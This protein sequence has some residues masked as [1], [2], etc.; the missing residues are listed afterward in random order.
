MD[1]PMAPS[2]IFECGAATTKGASSFQLLQMFAA[3]NKADNI[4]SRP[5]SR[6]TQARANMRNFLSC[7]G[8]TT[9][10][11]TGTEGHEKHRGSK[12]CLEP[13]GGASEISVLAPSAKHTLELLV[14]QCRA[15]LGEVRHI[16]SAEEHFVK[17]LK[18]E[19]KALKAQ[20][21]RL[22]AR[23]Q[24]SED[25]VAYLKTVAAKEEEKAAEMRQENKLLRA[26]ISNYMV[27]N[28][29]ARRAGH[30]TGAGR[31]SG[32]AVSS[33]PAEAASCAAGVLADREALVAM[34]T[35]ALDALSRILARAEA[36]RSQVATATGAQ[37]SAR[38]GGGEVREAARAELSV[39]ALEALLMEQ[40]VAVAT[41]VQELE[42]FKSKSSSALRQRLLRQEGKE[43][44]EGGVPG[45]ERGVVREPRVQA[46]VLCSDRRAAGDR[47]R[48]EEEVDDFGEEDEEVAEEEEGKVKVEVEET[49][50]VV[51]EEK[52]NH[53]I[54]L[55]EGARRLAAPLGDLAQ[56]VS[57]CMGAAAAI[58]QGLECELRTS[59]SRRLELV[60]ARLE[61]AHL[62]EQERAYVERIEQMER[63]GWEW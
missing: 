42:L 61:A 63:E 47:K 37:G 44:G 56:E 28:A 45:S 1:L 51:V 12:E 49:V 52:F 16:Q 9:S 54:P 30:V 41:H 55:A 19:Q 57:A 48:R 13:H 43:T 18:A 33:V 21:Q 23:L 59:E 11:E 20:M 60:Q 22:Q 4:R 29:Q 39:G 24:H 15:T 31:K 50:I 17:G 6:V 36:G 35:R 14:H 2:E 34:H 62:R 32:G 40:L 27:G 8:E 5:T 25:Q 46:R 3:G 10:C 53:S 26:N 58:A 38:A 7:D